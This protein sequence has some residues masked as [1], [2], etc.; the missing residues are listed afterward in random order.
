LDDHDHHSD[1][2]DPSSHLSNRRVSNTTIHRTSTLVSTA[3]PPKDKKPS[4]GLD[5]E[6]LQGNPSPTFFSA[7]LT[8][9]FFRCACLVQKSSSAQVQCDF[10]THEV[11]RHCETLRLG[12]GSQGSRCIGCPAQNAQGL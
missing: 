10:R 2:S 4:E 11:A 9:F 5:L 12:P 8:L 7:I 6:L 3:T 1:Y